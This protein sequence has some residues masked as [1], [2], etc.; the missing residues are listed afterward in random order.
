MAAKCDTV[1]ETATP[2]SHGFVVHLYFSTN[3]GTTE[4]FP[5]RLSYAP[6]YVLQARPELNYQLLA[7]KILLAELPPRPA[8][9]V[10]VQPGVSGA[11]HGPAGCVVSTPGRLPTGYRLGTEN[12]STWLHLRTFSRMGRKAGG[13]VFNPI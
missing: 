3:Q 5:A 1:N 7:S 9:T 11:V 12:V 13:P 10:E 8:N 6:R 4:L 2:R